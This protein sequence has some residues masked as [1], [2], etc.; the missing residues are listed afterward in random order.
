MDTSAV[1]ERK[2]KLRDTL[3]QA[4]LAFQQETGCVPEITVDH[5]RVEMVTGQVESFPKID[6]KVYL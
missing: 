3:T 1:K 6:I 4:I 2:L 5:M